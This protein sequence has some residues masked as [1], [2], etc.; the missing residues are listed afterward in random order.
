MPEE[1]ERR[2][3]SEWSNLKLFILSA[4]TWQII[5]IHFEKRKAFLNFQK[6]THFRTDRATGNRS[7][8]DKRKCLF[9]VGYRKLHFYTGIFIDWSYLG[10]L[11]VSRRNIFI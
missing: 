8:V 9:Y 1:A 3:S 4:L 2:S 5:L 10:A 11:D 7:G 6:L